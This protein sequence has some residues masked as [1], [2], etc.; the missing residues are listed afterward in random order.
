M[1]SLYHVSQGKYLSKT[2][3]SDTYKSPTL[4]LLLSFMSHAS[5]FVVATQEMS[6]KCL[7]LVVTESCIPGSHGTLRN[8]LVFL[9]SITLKSLCRKQNKTQPSLSWKRL[10]CHA[11]TFS[12]RNH[13]L[14][15]HTKRGQ[16][17]CTAGMRSLETLFVLSLYLTS[18][19]LYLLERTLYAI[20]ACSFL[21][22]PLKGHL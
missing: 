13:L 10:I 20:L 19:Y 18:D 12:L 8:K 9:G 7:P 14:L 2:G 21:W 5:V 1:F 3:A 4:C 22:L 11:W 15:W 6:L 17:N 16:L